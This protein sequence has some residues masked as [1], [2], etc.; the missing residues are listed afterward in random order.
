MFKI[1]KADGTTSFGATPQGFVA[2]DQELVSH[3]C[4]TESW[5]ANLATGAF[6]LGPAARH[7]H[8]L[9]DTGDL[10]LLNLVRCYDSGSRQ[11]VLGL[12]EMAAMQAS[13]FCFST[14]IIHDGGHL[15]MMCIG[16]SSNF[17]GNGGGSINGL[18]MFAHF[19]VA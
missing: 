8:G 16:E 11:H 3:F 18:F 14:T 19:V 7:Y 4:R 9:A 6:R 17:N 5:T 15:P 13:S 1:T 2:P 10:G 12:F